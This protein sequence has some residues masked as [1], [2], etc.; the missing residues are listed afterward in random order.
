MK[1]TIPEPQEFMSV[2]KPL[3][4]GGCADGLAREVSKR[5]TP[6]QLCGL[7]GCEDVDARRAV[8]VTVGLVGDVNVTR[9]LARALHDSDEQVNKMAEH[10]LWAIWFR[11]GSDRAMP[12]FRSG[13]EQLEHEQ[14][15]LAIQHLSQA[16]E[17]DHG[18]AEAHNQAAIAYYFLGDWPKAIHACREAIRHMPVHFGA[19]AGLG[20]CYAQIGELACSLHAYKHALRINPRM[21]AI[22]EA[23][24]KLA[25]CVSDDEAGEEIPLLDLPL[26]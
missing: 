19:V 6:G 13:V 11:A 9:C 18:F 2:V 14:Y 1:A 15:P 5:W 12:A 3:L 17:Q 7:L 24:N 20:H 26:Y 4:C 16:I 25:R 23:V 8:A 10:G 21:P 22:E